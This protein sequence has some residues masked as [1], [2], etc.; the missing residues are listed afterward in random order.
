MF[1]LSLS[2]LF[3]FFWFFFQSFPKL[4]FSSFLLVF[5]NTFWSLAIPPFFPPFL[6][7]YL[8]VCFQTQQTY[9]YTSAPPHQ[10]QLAFL[11]FTSSSLNIVVFKN[12]T[13][14]SSFLILSSSDKDITGLILFSP[15]L[16]VFFW[17]LT[18]IWENVWF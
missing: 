11:F 12:C 17:P 2:C 7:Q 16:K 13:S 10:T 3:A 1:I 5:L 15:V 14:S 8:P 6:F 9:P 18:S 4:R